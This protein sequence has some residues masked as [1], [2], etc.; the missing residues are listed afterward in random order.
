MFR[1][2]IESDRLHGLRA[3]LRPAEM[4]G[5]KGCVQCGYCCNVR[6]CIPT[7]DEL[8]VIA[9]FLK[10][11]TEALIDEYFVIDV[12]DDTNYFLKPAGENTLEYVGEFLPASETFGEGACVFLKENKCKIY[13]VRP[14]SARQ[15]E[16][17]NKDEELFDAKPS[18]ADDQLQKRFD[19][20]GSHYAAG[21]DEGGGLFGMFDWW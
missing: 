16:C 7:P 1:Q 20:N 9:E 19:M 8:V 11:S 10:V 4:R 2:S 6:S 14:K 5:A 17:W 18:W 21:A 3:K 12:G 13:E 15:V